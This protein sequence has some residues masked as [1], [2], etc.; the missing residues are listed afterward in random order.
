MSVYIKWCRNRYWPL[1]PTYLEIEGPSEKAVYDIVKLLGLENAKV[2]SKDVSSIY[3]DYGHDI[4]NIFE[5]KLEEER[6]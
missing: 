2:T 5:L 1:I 6:K 4:T 3:L